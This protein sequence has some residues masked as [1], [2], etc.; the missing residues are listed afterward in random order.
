M[1]GLRVTS[2]ITW[3]LK[4]WDQVSYFHTLATTFTP[5]QHNISGPQFF[6]LQ[7]LEGAV[8]NRPNFY[9]FFDFID[10]ILVHR[11]V[12]LVKVTPYLSCRCYQFLFALEVSLSILF[13]GFQT[14]TD[15]VV[16]YYIVL[17]VL[18]DVAIYCY[19]H[20]IE[21]TDCI[22]KPTIMVVL[23]I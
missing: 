12:Y 5:V 3:P 4:N 15:L 20:S 18:C 21:Y 14:F 11:R 22:Y 1:S 9:W 8:Q 16:W 23:I 17:V 10:R 19:Y 6:Y 13:V 2:S 7:W